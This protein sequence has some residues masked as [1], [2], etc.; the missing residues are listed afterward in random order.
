M[1]KAKRII[2]G[3]DPGTSTS[4]AAFDLDGKFLGAETI[5]N[6]GKE[7]IIEEILKHGI[8]IVV[9]TDVSTPP[10]F[11]AQVASN[12]SARLFVPDRDMLQRD[13]ED[14]T[15]SMREEKEIGST[16]ER[17]AAGAALNFIKHYKNKMA[18][19]DRNISEK[20]LIELGDEIK[21]YVLQGVPLDSV[22]DYLTVKEKAE[23]EVKK[24]EVISEKESRR[25]EEELEYLKELMKSNA[26]LRS[27]LSVMSSENRMLKDRLKAVEHEF[28]A[29]ISEDK[30]LKGKDLQI[31][32]LQTLLDRQSNEMS[33][34]EQSLKMLKKNVD[35]GEKD[36]RS[37]RELEKDELEKL[38]DLY[39][40]ERE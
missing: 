22:I 4:F 29:G 6:P 40:E 30:V 7:G 18:W 28:H 8:P 19:L 15:R 17:D 34:L 38:V 36:K 26:Q 5:R 10:E 3:L 23:K 20:G 31:K 2:I 35:T 21:S 33:R 13:K 16:H 37:K 32:R 25:R 1:P 24:G 39:K 27:F 14:L 11:V 12:F 9:A